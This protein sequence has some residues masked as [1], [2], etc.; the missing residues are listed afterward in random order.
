MACG[1]TT[2]FIACVAEETQRARSLSLAC[3]DGK[4]A[5]TEDLGNVGRAVEREGHNAGDEAGNVDKAEEVQARDGD[6][7]KETEVDDRELHA[8][9][10]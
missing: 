5:R 7:A 2:S 1:S 10:A 8:A 3:V 4:D 9:A 6:R